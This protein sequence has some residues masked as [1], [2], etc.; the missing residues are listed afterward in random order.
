MEIIKE[1]RGWQGHFI[2]RCDYHRNTLI[3]DQNGSK[4]YVVSTVG[5][6]RGID[7]KN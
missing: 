1:E 7:G 6:M 3:F 2:C 4:R 5:N